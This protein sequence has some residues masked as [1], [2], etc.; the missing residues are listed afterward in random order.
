MNYIFTSESVSPGHPDKTCDAIS[1][2]L[3]DFAL[4]KNPY[5]RC[6]FESFAT[7]NNVIIG[8]ETNAS[9]SKLETEEVIRNTLKNIGH[10][11][12]GFHY[13]DVKITKSNN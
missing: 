8:G 10:A 3:L 13:N 2:A 12:E 5:A 6:A 7:K 11:S 4:T 9:I 1:D